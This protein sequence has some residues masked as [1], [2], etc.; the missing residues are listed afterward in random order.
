M[1]ITVNVRG[2]VTYRGVVQGQYSGVPYRSVVN[3]IFLLDA[4]QTIPGDSIEIML[5]SKND[6]AWKIRN[7]SGYTAIIMPIELES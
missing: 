5:Q 2:R 6:E 4:I 3:D 7:S 1:I